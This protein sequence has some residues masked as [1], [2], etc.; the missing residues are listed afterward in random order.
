MIKDKNGASGDYK[1]FA[2]IE[3]FTIEDATFVLERAKQDRLKINNQQVSLSYSRFKRPEQYVTLLAIIFSMSH[4]LSIPR[5]SIRQR[6]LCT[7]APSLHLSS[8]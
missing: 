3:F 8:Q 2:F 1:D 4:S 7:L 6:P 5:A